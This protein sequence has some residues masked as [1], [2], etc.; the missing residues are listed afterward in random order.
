MPSVPAT[1]KIRVTVAVEEKDLGVFM[2]HEGGGVSGETTKIRPGADEAEVILAAVKT[3]ADL[4]VNGLY[5]DALRARRLWLAE[6]INKGEMVVSM[7]PLDADGNAFGSPEV[8]RGQL[9]GFEPP[10]SDANSTGD[11][12]AAQCSVTMAVESWA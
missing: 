3:F 12:S 5:T 9:T 11:G 1:N 8:V 10:G 4:T 6:Q 7:Q 2:S